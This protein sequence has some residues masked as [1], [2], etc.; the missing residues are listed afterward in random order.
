[1]PIRGGGTCEF[2]RPFPRIGE[3]Q[4]L[5]CAKF[6]ALADVIPRSPHAD[7]RCLACSMRC[8]GRHERCPCCG[9]VP[10]VLDD[11]CDVLS[12][13]WTI[14]RT[15][16]RQYLD[17]RLVQLPALRPRV[18]RAHSE[19]TTRRFGS[20]RGLRAERDEQSAALAGGA[21]AV[22]EELAGLQDCSATIFSTSMLVMM[23]TG[24]LP[25]VTT[26]R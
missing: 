25:C 11:R 16:A 4:P 8:R 26:N 12:R 3:V 18:V 24:S 20:G 19:R 17:S 14:G 21:T 10:D 7:R 2:P 23:P 5:H 15:G 22:Q 1:V 13:L 6:Y 9:H